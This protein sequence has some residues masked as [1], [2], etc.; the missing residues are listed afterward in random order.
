[1]GSESILKEN[2][3]TEKSFKKTIA[4]NKDRIL[5]ETKKI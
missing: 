2:K 1:M 3:K 4:E 5:D